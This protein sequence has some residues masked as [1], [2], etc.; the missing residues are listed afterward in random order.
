MARDG[1]APRRSGMRSVFTSLLTVATVAAV[2]STSSARNGVS[3]A[4]ATAGAAQASMN[5]TQKFAGTY[6]LITTEQKDASGKWVQTPNFNSNGYIIYS[7]TGQMAVHI[8]PKIRPKV[9]TPPTADE[10]KAAITGYTA[11]FGTY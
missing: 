3:A 1:R 10:A 6:A 11:Y 8:Q 4:A 2:L 7:P 9:S 5:D